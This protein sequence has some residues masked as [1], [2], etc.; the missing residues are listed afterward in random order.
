[1]ADE[2]LEAADITSICSG[3]NINIGTLNERTIKSMFISGKKANELNI[4][5]LLDPVGAGAIGA[6][7][8]IRRLSCSTK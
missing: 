2:P 4:P 3:L 1:M 6:P 8:P 7:E 5:V